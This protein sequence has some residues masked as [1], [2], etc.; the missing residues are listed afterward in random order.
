[1]TGRTPTKS[2]IK[3][4][5]EGNPLF[6]GEVALDPHTRDFVLAHE[7]VYRED[8][9]AGRGFPEEFFPFAAASHVLDIGCGPGIWTRELAR[10]DFT[11][12]SID[13]TTTA[14]A[15]TRRS[16]ELFGLS[17]T[18]LEADA[19]N[20]PFAD[21]SFDGVVSHGVIHHTPRT[22]ACVSEIGRVLRPGGVAVV[23]VY[24]RNLVL[25]SKILSRLA[26]LALGGWVK[27]PG[28]GRD[29]LLRSGEAD[30]IVRLYDGTGNPLGQAFTRTDFEAMFHQAG[31]RVVHRR[32]Y[33]FPRR[34]FG[35][36][37]AAL[38]PLHSLLAA[39]LGLMIAVVARKEC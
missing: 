24:Y 3:T 36:A 13:L 37:G 31:M 19:E 32:R 27:L 4:F 15:I 21:A 39:R 30:E 1:M 5:W 10:R 35:R 28:R 6:S 2:D 29:E 26:G 14:I 12:T 16:L 22:G 17:A 18:L 38:K 9:F 33:Y 11:T 8:V 23:S 25:R 20:L 7:K 34:A